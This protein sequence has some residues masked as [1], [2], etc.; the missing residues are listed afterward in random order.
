MH[1]PGVTFGGA[2]FGFAQD[3]SEMDEIFDAGQNKMLW[4]MD[5]GNAGSAVLH[6]LVGLPQ[7]QSKDYEDRC[8][9]FMFESAY[10]SID[11]AG[12]QIIDSKTEKPF[13]LTAKDLA[14]DLM[15]KKYQRCEMEE[16]YDPDI[17]LF[18]PN[19]TV[20]AGARHRIYKKEDDHI[21]DAD[22]TGILALVLPRE[23]DVSIFS[24]SANLRP[25]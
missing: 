19:H 24:C 12:N 15:V 13:K 10:E 14:T 9:G 22:R 16:P 6:N 17:M 25:S 3:P 4:G 8:S 7:Y 21:I 18:Y 20:Q 1:A 2:D 23:E 11:E 5:V